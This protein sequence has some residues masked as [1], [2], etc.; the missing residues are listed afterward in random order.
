MSMRKRLTSIRNTG[1]RLQDALG[2]VSGPG[3]VPIPLPLVHVS[4]ARYFDSIVREGCLRPRPCRNFREDILYLFY[5]GAFY[6]LN[7]RPVRDASAQ[8]VAFLFDPS[9]L[10]A[11]ERY[12]PLDTGALV[13]GY[14]GK[15][16]TDALLP[17]DRWSVSGCGDYNIPCCLVHYIFGS[18]RAY[19]AGDLDPACSALPDP[20]PLLFNFFSADLSSHGVDKRQMMIECHAARDLPLA[21]GLLWVALPECAGAEFAHHIYNWTKPS[22]PEW[23]FYPAHRIERPSALTEMI[24]LK[25][26]EFIDGRFLKAFA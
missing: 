1:A 25:A 16:W 10:T 3:E 21:T 20:F 11:I 15:E 19:L 22:M 2:T 6:R 13:E 9:V 5:G 24:S 26:R 12:Y 8:P 14:F 7:D 17:A 23:F 18:N 4:V